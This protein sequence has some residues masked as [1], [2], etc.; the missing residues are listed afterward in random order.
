MRS[1]VAH[2]GCVLLAFEDEA[3]L[4]CAALRPLDR[5]QAEMKRLY[6]RPAGRG[7]QLGRKLAQE[8]CGAARRRGYRHLRLDTLPHMKAAQQL[9]M[10]LGFV[11][12][13]AYVHN[14][15]EGTRFLELDLGDPVRDLRLQS[16][17]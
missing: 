1:A 2:G 12:V 11:E 13:D 14:P 9:Y 17:Q 6:V 15:I 4:G 5:Q 7:R 16:G 10:A 3:L 8:I